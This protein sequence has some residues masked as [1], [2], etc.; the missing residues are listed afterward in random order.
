MGQSPG[1]QCRIMRSRTAHATGA[2]VCIGGGFSRLLG[3]GKSRD[4]GPT[5]YATFFFASTICQMS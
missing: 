4:P 5:R 2:S 3:H 1:R